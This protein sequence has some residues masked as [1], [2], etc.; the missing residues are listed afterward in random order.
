ME[1]RTLFVLR[2]QYVL[3]IFRLNP[4]CRLNDKR[5]RFGIAARI[6]GWPATVGLRT[7]DALIA[8]RPVKLGSRQ[9]MNIRGMCGWIAFP[10]ALRLAS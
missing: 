1:H 3:F 2:S 10:K 9:Q 7:L 6:Y 8:E 4:H 5:E